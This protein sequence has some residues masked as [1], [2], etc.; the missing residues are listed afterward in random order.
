MKKAQVVSARSHYHVYVDKPSKWQSPYSH[1]KDARKL[2]LIPT[3]T[4][5]EAR[6]LY[7]EWI[8]KGAGSH[9]LNDLHELSGKKLGCWAHPKASHADVLVEL[10][11]QN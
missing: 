10:L 8:T 11:N 6:D 3:N 1:R 5:E 7:R 4:P 2:G 9:L